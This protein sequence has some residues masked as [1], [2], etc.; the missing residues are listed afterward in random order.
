MIG[1]S[2][3]AFVPAM[4]LGHPHAH[5]LAQ[6]LVHLPLGNGSFMF[7]L[8]ANVGAVI[9]PWMIFFQQGAVIDKG[10]PATSMRSERVDTAVGAVLTQLVMIAVVVALATTVGRHHPGAALGTVGQISTALHPFL[11][12]F[13]AKVLFGAGMLGAALVA[14]LVSSLAGAWGLSEVFGWEHTL[15][16]RPDRRTARFYLT[17]ALAHIIGAGLV[18]TSLNLIS[19]A[20][21]VEV[22]NALLLPIVLGFLLALEARALPPTQRMRGWRRYT[23]WLMCLLVIGFGLYMLPA[24]L[25]R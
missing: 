16:E 12:S 24:L 13:G 5:A 6:G 14:A 3:L 17:Y 25:F 4:I 1:L 2:E 11:G 18:L 15:N 9:M 22:M 20:V 21:D 8:A 19:L 10:L 7:L 23:T